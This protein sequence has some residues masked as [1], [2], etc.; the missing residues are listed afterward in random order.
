LLVLLQL[1]LGLD[2]EDREGEDRLL[3]GVRQLQVGGRG[4]WSGC[5]WGEG[6]AE[7]AG[8]AEGESSR[9]GEWAAEV[10]WRRR[11]RT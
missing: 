5:G 3:G 1:E 2:G 9:R 4:G 11:G 10:L 6:S 8:D 7:G